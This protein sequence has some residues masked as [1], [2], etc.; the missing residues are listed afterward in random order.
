MSPQDAELDALVARLVDLGR[1]ELEICE[2]PR[3]LALVPLVRERQL[4]LAR[5]A[6]LT[7]GRGLE[8]LATRTST[9][10]GVERI[11]ELSRRA[12][13]LLSAHRDDCVQGLSQV[14]QRHNAAMSYART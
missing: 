14:R 13:V 3:L 11:L 10:E 12:L 6:Q 1:R 7:G 5:I 4:V 9:A 8:A 2:A